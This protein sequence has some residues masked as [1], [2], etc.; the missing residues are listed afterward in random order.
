MIRIQKKIESETLRLPELKPLIGKTVQIIVVEEPS[1]P[2]AEGDWKELERLARDLEGY[3]FDAWRQ[4]R[5][6]SHP[7]T[8]QDWIEFFAQGGPIDI[9]AAASAQQPD[10]DRQRGPS[11]APRQ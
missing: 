2:A 6:A 5:A 3:D 9:D 8:E 1:A 11:A 7:A 10:F 4:L